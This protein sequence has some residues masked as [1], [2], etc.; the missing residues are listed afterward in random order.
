[1]KIEMD[2]AMNVIWIVEQLIENEDSSSTEAEVFKNSR[3]LDEHIPWI[4]KSA[5]LIDLTFDRIFD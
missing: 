5:T 3:W 2:M 1:M 4:H